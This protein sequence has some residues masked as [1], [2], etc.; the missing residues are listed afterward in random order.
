MKQMDAHAEETRIRLSE[1]VRESIPEGLAAF[2]LYLAL[3]LLIFGR[4]AIGD[5]NAVCACAGDGDPTSFMWTFEWW[6]HAILNGLNP[7]VPDIV[8]AP[9]GANLTQGGFAI[10]AAAIALAPVTLAVGPV[11]AYNV[12]SVLMPVL[13]AWFAYRLCRYLTGAV[14]P[15][16]M[17][18]FVFGFGT[19]MSAHLLGHLNLTS[20]FLAPAAVHL[21][22]LRLDEVISRRRFIVLMAIVFAVQVLLSAEILLL[23]LG[24]GALALALAYAL[25]DRERRGRIARIVPVTIAAGGVAML[26]ASP[27]LYWILDGLGDADSQA[28]RTFT[29]L[30]PGDALNPVVP[31]EVTGLGHWWFDDMTSKFTNFT[32]SEAAA[33]VGPV[34]LAIVIGFAVTQWRRP[35]TRV[36]VPVIAVCYV[37]SLGTSLHVAG[38]DTGIWMPWAILHP[39]PILDHVISTRIWVFALLAIAI[40]LA[41]WL[42]EPSSRTGLKW[43]V[44]AVGVVLLIPNFTSDSW[45]GRPTDPAFFTTDTYYEHLRE[46]DTVLALPYARN[47]SSMLWQA[48]T[49]MYFKMVQGYVSPEFPPGYRDDPFL[50]ELL[51]ED[52]GENDV[53]GLRDFL[54]RRGVTAVVVEEADTGPWPFLLAALRLEPVKA[55]GVL[56]YRVPRR[57]GAQ[58][59]S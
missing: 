37:L 30:Y 21:V 44:G 51:G 52:V 3:S 23:G 14:G 40:A 16:L 12:A 2:L 48:E 56:V 35:A 54:T 20:V 41:L 43:A 28:W 29:A 58:A 42:A 6:P 7:F 18:G 5:P 32:R 46:G 33:Y 34:L 1:R 59:A 45:G 15:S 13:A 26:V 11:V 27:Y 19:Y 24:V 47:G 38:D 10:P 8:W 50:D 57:L 36:L 49:G 9:E 25:A 39:L 53:E 4:D 17:G 31:T 55:G 22:L